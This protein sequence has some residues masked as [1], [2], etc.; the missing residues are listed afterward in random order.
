MG[1]GGGLK[2]LKEEE[3]GMRLIKEEEMKRIKDKKVGKKKKGGC[4]NLICQEE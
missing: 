2:V 1:V 4:A 3:T